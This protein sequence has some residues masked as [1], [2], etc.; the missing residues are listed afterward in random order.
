MTTQKTWWAPVWRGLVVAPEAKHY[1]RMKNSVWLFL[2]L[3]LHADRRSGR[4]KRKCRTI[5]EEMG[6]PEKTIQRWMKTLKDYG[7]IETRNTGRCLE[8]GV[9][10]WKSF[11][12]SSNPG[13]QNT[14]NWPSRSDRREESDRRRN[15]P[16]LFN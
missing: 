2:H 4:L 9:K 3:V 6:V 10:L 7:Y 11:L 16:K 1:R 13:N 15:W 12:Q 8:I 5:A 14:R